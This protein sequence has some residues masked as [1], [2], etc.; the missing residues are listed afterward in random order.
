LAVLPV[1]GS[2]ALPCGATQIGLRP[3]LGVAHTSHADLSV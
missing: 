3:A 2:A 1:R